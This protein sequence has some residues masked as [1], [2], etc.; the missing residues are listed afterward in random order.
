MTRL[1]NV[2]QPEVFTP[3][4]IKRTMELSALVQCGIMVNSAEFDALA[5][6]PNTLINM[7]FWEDLVGEEETVTQDGYYTPL[8]INASKDVARKQMFGNSWGVNNL[9]AL[10]SGDDPMAAIGDLVSDYWQRVLQKRFL[11]TIEGIFNSKSM[12]DLVHDISGMAGNAGLLTGESFIDAGQLM[13]DAKDRLTGAMMHSATEAHLAKR[14]LIDYV[15]ESAQSD[16]IPY[17]MRKRVIV[18][19]GMHYDT[20]TKVGDM[21]LFGA[22]AIALGNGSHPNIEETETSRDSTSHAGDNYLTNRRII[23]LHP[24]G[25]KWTE[26]DVAG[27]F[28]KKEELKKASNWD[29]VYE[30]KQIRIVKHRFR[31]G[32]WV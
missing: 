30:K 20:A 7:P 9:A 24:R 18:D 31:L 13:G 10:L 26:E 2:I 27:I 22:G 16:R 14:G 17:F 29:R 5:S 23:V 32:E 25:V 4:V 12:A 8:G 28:P 19:D 11:A 21:Y 6:G 1:E 3:Y 15:Q